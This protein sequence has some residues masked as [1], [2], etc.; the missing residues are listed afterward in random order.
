MIGERN[1]KQNI[2]CR[3]AFSRALGLPTGKLSQGL[4]GE[5]G[6]Q[7]AGFPDDLEWKGSRLLGHF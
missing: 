5:P 4:V 7:L 2:F 6:S 1:K 3:N